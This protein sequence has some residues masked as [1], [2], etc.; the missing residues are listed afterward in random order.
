MKYLGLLAC[1]L[2]I[3]VADA[4][5]SYSERE[6][7]SSARGSEK[8]EDWEEDSIGSSRAATLRRD[9]T[10]ANQ[11]SNRSV[12]SDRCVDSNGIMFYKNDDGYR[13]CVK[14]NKRSP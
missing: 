7:E 11:E 6:R 5:Y 3:S 13:N 12:T 14:M 4:N 1:F 9:T 8:R 10:R 2:S